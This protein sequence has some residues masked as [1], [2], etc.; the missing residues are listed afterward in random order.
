MIVGTFVRTF[1]ESTS[2]QSL[3]K[4]IKKTNANNDKKDISVFLNNRR[5]TITKIKNMKTEQDENTRNKDAFKTVSKFKNEQK[6]MTNRSR[7]IGLNIKTTLTV[8]T[9]NTSK[10]LNKETN[11]RILTDKRTSIP[12]SPAREES[13]PFNNVKRKLETKKSNK[14][15]NKKETVKKNVGIKST[16]NLKPCTK[17]ESNTKVKKQNSGQIHSMKDLSYCFSLISPSAQT[18]EKV[19]IVE[20]IIPDTDDIPDSVGTEDELSMIRE[21]DKGKTEVFG[22]ALPRVIDYLP[23]EECRALAMTNRSAFNTFLSKSLEKLNANIKELEK[24]DKGTIELPFK[25]SPSS[26]EKIWEYKEESILQAD[27]DTREMLCFFIL[28]A[29][30]EELPWDSAQQLLLEKARNGELRQYIWEVLKDLKPTNKLTYIMKKYIYR[31]NKWINKA[32]E[33][34]PILIELMKYSGVIDPT[35]RQRIEQ[36]KY[37]V[38]CL[39]E[40]K[41]RINKG[42]KA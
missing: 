41:E 13:K 3:H 20:S 30:G 27:K 33:K 2:H 18:G 32:K 11:T 15:L 19:V 42:R 40:I 29:K 36:M 4:T 34:L 24:G 10:M 21:E 12:G 1:V 23:N 28:I 9:T 25:L 8:V 16:K 17:D 37:R 6:T 35:V 5:N 14:V 22:L 26:I 38:K 39:Q 7:N 31:N